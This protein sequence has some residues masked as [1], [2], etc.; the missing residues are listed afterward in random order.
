MG[1]RLAP[2]FRAVSRLGGGE[3]R[4]AAARG[5]PARQP[6]PE[7]RPTS[8]LDLM[9]EPGAAS[10][11]PEMLSVTAGVGIARLYRA[12]AATVADLLRPTHDVAMCAVKS[13]AHRTAPRCI[14]DP[15]LSPAGGAQLE[16]ENARCTR[17]H[18]G[19]TSWCCYQPKVDVRS[20]AHGRCRGADATWRRGGRLVPP[21]DF[22]PLARETGPDQLPLSEWSASAKAA[23]R[24]APVAEQLR[25]LPP[26]RSP[27]A[28]RAGCFERTDTGRPAC[29]ERRSRLRRPAP[30][31]SSSR[32][33]RPGLMEGSCRG[34]IPVAAPASAA[35]DVEIA[36]RRL[37][38][39]LFLAGY[40]TALPDLQA[41]EDRPQLRARPAATTAAVSGD[42]HRD[43]RRWHA[44]AQPARHRRG[45][46]R[47]C[48][49]WRALHKAEG[50]WPDAGF[51]SAAR[52]AEPRTSRLWLLQPMLPRRLHGSAGQQGRSQRC[53][54]APPPRTQT[55][56]LTL[57]PRRFMDNTS[58]RQAALRRLVLDEARTDAPGWTRVPMRR[59]RAKAPGGDNNASVIHLISKLVRGVERVERHWTCGTPKDNTARC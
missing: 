7:A 48:A 28:C 6:T 9:R 11:R 57:S 43:H 5:R 51:C 30:H 49:R 21:G 38:H 36:D 41:T 25:L 8:I 2:R 46:R 1:S 50:C 14:Y 35:S 39:R 42:R 12:T 27:S 16:L 13:Q 55:S 4:R 44:L 3:V 52:S 26:G 53:P 23:R 22:I 10:K 20:R 32:S 34:V 59:N 58:S 15:Q 18:R 40:L 17:T 19:A 31:R 24:A 45:R 37:R 29:T 56:R 54:A 33:P 47:A